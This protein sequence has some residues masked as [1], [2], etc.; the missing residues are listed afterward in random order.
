MWFSSIG[1]GTYLGEEDDE[2]DNRSF[3]AVR[4]A[5]ALGVNVIDTAINYRAQR[6]E[7]TLGRAISAMLEGGDL[8]RE[9]LIVCTK[10]GYVPFD[11]GPPRDPKAYFENNFVKTG[12]VRQGDL[13]GGCHCMAPRYLEAQIAASRKNLGLATLDVYYVHNPEEQGVAADR[14]IFRERLRDAFETLEA[15]VKRGEIGLY[16]VATWQGF[17]ESPDAAGYLGLEEVVG[18]AREAGGES[19][20]FRFVQLPLNLAMPEAITRRNQT[21]EGRTIT[22]VEAADHLGVTLVASASLLQ[23]RL[24]QG[25]SDRVA[26]VFTGF[27]TDAQRAL[28]FVR[29]TPGISVALVGMKQLEHVEENLRVARVPP[30][31]MERYLRLFEKAGEA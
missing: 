16:G 7:R 21:V 24:A 9:D 25:L 15:A 28:Q 11:G 4:R 12:L 17:R 3:E 22:L 26:R 30:V 13:A 31:A 29:S 14:A 6:S 19:H 23:A 10:G 2:E 27:E 5:V 1:L 18:L 20:H 8:A